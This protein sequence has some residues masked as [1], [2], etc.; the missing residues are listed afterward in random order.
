MQTT[1]VMPLNEAAQTI[2]D[3]GIEF[4]TGSGMSNFRYTSLVFKSKKDAWKAHDLVRY[5]A[6]ISNNFDGTYELKWYN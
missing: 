5:N 2:R 4:T 6:P 3:A 1:H